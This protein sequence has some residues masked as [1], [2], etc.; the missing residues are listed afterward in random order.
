MHGVVEGCDKRRS[1]DSNWDLISR[2]IF[3]VSSECITNGIRM[4][5]N[6]LVFQI[7]MLTSNVVCCKKIILVD[8]MITGDRTIGGFAC[9]TLRKQNFE[10]LFKIHWLHSPTTALI[11]VVT[12]PVTL[13]CPVLCVNIEY[14]TCG[15]IENV[16]DLRC[17]M[18]WYLIYGLEASHG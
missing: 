5:H 15:K 18:I 7:L 12:T 11:S 4:Y 10:K 17:S 6:V 3:I 14:L 2:I 8:W 1:L 16:L 9:I 13:L